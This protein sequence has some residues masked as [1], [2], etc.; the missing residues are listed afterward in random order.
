VSSVEGEAAAISAPHARGNAGAR[1]RRGWLAL[2]LVLICVFAALALL[3][4]FSSEP[5]GPA[6][7]S[8][9]TGEK[10]VAA[11]ATLLGRTGHPVNQLRA[12]LDDARIPPN[13]TLVL[14]EPDALLHSEGIR[15]MAFVRAGGR[16]LYGSAEPRRTLPALLVASPEWGGGGADRYLSYRSEGDAAEDVREVRTDG[17]GAWTS[18][19]GYAAP[20]RA[21]DGRALLLQKRIGNGV[22][23]LLADVS[24]LQNRLLATADNARLALS[25]VGPPGRPVSFV[26]SVHGY[27]TA[28]GLAALPIGW[29][30]AL[31]GLL[32]AGLLWI[33]ARARRLGPAEPTIEAPPPPRSAYADAVAL[34]LRRTRD[35]A[36]IRET[37]ERWTGT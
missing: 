17:E 34:L 35:E 24:P 25:I 37:L 22:L 23:E 28:R 8:Y 26:E 11:W 18:F 1:A 14:L 13:E 20:V 36:A 6:S 10:G 12:S 30:F 21:A 3:G 29:R 16:L 15:L 5:G 9:S 32:L 31:A 33:A 4:G 2:G 19:A 7:S 27:G